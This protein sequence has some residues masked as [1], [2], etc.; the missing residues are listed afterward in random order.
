MMISKTDY[1]KNKEYWDYQ[2]LVEY[3]RE[4]AWEELQILAEMN[5]IDADVW[6]HQFWNQVEEED[7]DTPPYGWEPKDP[8]YR[9]DK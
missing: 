7:Y 3:N 2:R 8:K 9:I 6:W 1:Q 5:D 4:K